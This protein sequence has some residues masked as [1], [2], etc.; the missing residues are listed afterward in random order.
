MRSVAVVG[1]QYGGVVGCGF[2]VFGNP[3]NNQKPTT[4]NPENKTAPLTWGQ[5][6]VL[7]LSAL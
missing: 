3:T 5:V 1:G 2:S 6:K 7:F 4:N